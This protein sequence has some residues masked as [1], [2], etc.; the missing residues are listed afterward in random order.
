[1]LSI[2]S[3]VAKR[4]DALGAPPRLYRGDL[5][6]AKPLAKDRELFAD[7]ADPERLYLASYVDE[8]HV[9][10]FEGPDTVDEVAHLEPVSSAVK[11]AAIIRYTKAVTQCKAAAKRSSQAVVKAA[12]EKVRAGMGGTLGSDNA[13][14][15]TMES[16]EESREGELLCQAL[17]AQFGALRSEARALRWMESH[18][19]EACAEA[20]EDGSGT[21]SAKEAT[22][23]W[24][25]MLVAVTRTYTSKLDQLG[26]NP[27]PLVL[28][29]GDLCMVR[30]LPAECDA[31]DPSRLYLATYVDATHAVFLDDGG[32]AVCE[33]ARLGPATTADKDVAVVKYMTALDQC[34]RLAEADTEELVADAIEQVRAG[35]GGDLG[36]D[37]AIDYRV[38]AGEEARE[39]QLL[40]EALIQNVGALWD[41]SRSL[42]WMSEHW[43]EVCAKADEDTS[44]TISEEEA[45]EIW[46]EVLGGFT[47]MVLEK[48]TLLG[49]A[50]RGGLSA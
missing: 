3:T 37:G 15:Y 33:V 30:P 44:G 19:R 26:V 5:V 39:G 32:E 28:A 38:E 41:E 40:C 17:L 25:R 48:L 18:W 13:I 20:D 9:T 29:A 27:A 35:M 47:K 22:L 4:L 7:P 14:D 6:C 34:R 42:R 50:S 16:G 36:A 23:I 46:D 11:E 49:S 45:V 21:I 31:A 24:D 12:I 1:M 2:S 8:S 43:Q 10:F